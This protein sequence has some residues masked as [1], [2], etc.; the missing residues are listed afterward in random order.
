M[1][2]TSID[3]VYFADNTIVKGDF[4]RNHGSNFGVQNNRDLYRVNVVNFSTTI[5]VNSVQS[6]WVDDRYQVVVRDGY[7]RVASNE[8]C[9]LALNVYDFSGRCVLSGISSDSI[10]IGALPKGVYILHVTGKG[11]NHSI[12]LIL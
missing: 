8:L 2:L 3:G 12:K 7:L 5:D 1:G 9:D 6:A 11:V 4:D 10:Y